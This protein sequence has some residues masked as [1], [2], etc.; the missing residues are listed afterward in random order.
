L[1]EVPADGK[2]SD[3]FLGAASG[4]TSE[5]VHIGRLIDVNGG[6]RFVARLRITATID[7]G[8]GEVDFADSRLF[9]LLDGRSIA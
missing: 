7:N 4:Q 6:R 3:G 8:T 9:G 5:E 1:L 2:R